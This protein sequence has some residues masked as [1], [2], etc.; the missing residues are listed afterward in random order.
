[1]GTCASQQA[2]EQKASAVRGRLQVETLHAQYVLTNG[3]SFLQ[4]EQRFQNDPSGP[5]P[6]PRRCVHA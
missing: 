1:M 6:I 3:S 2:T 5:I 4:V